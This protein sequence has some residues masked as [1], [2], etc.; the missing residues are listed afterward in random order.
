MSVTDTIGHRSLRPDIPRMTALIGLF[1]QI[2]G[3]LRPDSG[4]KRHLVYLMVIL[5][6][7]V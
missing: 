5:G 3:V 1:E 6:E 4:G 2:I 7:E